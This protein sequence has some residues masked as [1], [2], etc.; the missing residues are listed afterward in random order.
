MKTDISKKLKMHKFISILITIV[1]IAL[2]TF[3][4]ITEDEPGGIPLLLILAGTVWY[5]YTRSKTQ[6]NPDSL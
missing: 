6:S 5:F 4:I 1:G 2:M 3:M